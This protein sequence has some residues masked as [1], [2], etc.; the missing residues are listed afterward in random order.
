M[1]YLVY[2]EGIFSYLIL[3]IAFEIQFDTITNKKP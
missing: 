1:Q 3:K 2:L